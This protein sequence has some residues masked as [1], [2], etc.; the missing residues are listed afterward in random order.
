MNRELQL[1]AMIVPAILMGTW[2]VY[3]AITSRPPRFRLSDY[4]LA[5]GKIGPTRTRANVIGGNISLANGL[6]YFVVLGYLDGVGGITA[7]I[8]WGI[9]LFC[10]RFLTPIIL[11][12]ARQG[13]TLHGFLG[14]SFGSPN[15]RTAC[16]FVTTFGYLLNFGFETFVGGTIMASVLGGDPRLRWV[17]VIALVGANALYISMAGFLG[18][19]S[20]DRKQNAI[21]TATIGALLIAVVAGLYWS[22]SASTSETTVAPLFVGLSWTKYLGIIAYTLTF[23]MVGALPC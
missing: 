12:A 11:Q 6:W 1:A 15:L 20:Q 19:I 3:K 22:G 5:G 21:G 13:E 7:Q 8:T 18:N 4:F 23:P 9:A 14:T 17:F 2:L 16:A 10:M